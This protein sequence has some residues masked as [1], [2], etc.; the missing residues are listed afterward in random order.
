VTLS[1]EGGVMVLFSFSREG[2]GLSVPV[3]LGPASRRVVALGL[4]SQLLLW[5]LLEASECAR[6]AATRAK[7]KASA[8][9]A[10]KALLDAREQA[11]QVQVA[12]VSACLSAHVGTSSPRSA[13]AGRDQRRFADSGKLAHTHA[14]LRACRSRAQVERT[15]REPWRR[16]R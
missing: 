15:T 11:I 9:K 8:S 7:L 12:A 13:P 4:A 14:H 6:V 2:R 1:A 10:G 3:L 16:G 5:G